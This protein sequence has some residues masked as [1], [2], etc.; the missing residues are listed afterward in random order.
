M[1]RSF[2]QMTA[3]ILTLGAS[4][5]LLKSNFG[6]TPETIAKISST[7][8]DHNKPVAKSFAQ[9][10][11]DTRVGIVLLLT[12]FA[13]QLINALWPMR[14]KD[15]GISW[16]GIFVSIGVCAIILTISCWY[17][18]KIAEKINKDTVQIF[19]DRRKLKENKNS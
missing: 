9:Q 5:F 1:I 15:F 11:A 19:E 8:W 18:K 12:A 7:Y 10:S 3:L 6:L 2:V 17:S 16:H 4:I 13:L 14:W